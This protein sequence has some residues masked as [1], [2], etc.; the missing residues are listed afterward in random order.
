MAHESFTKPQQPKPISRDDTRLNAESKIRAAVAVTSW[1]DS[2][3]QGEQEAVSRIEAVSGIPEK[4]T[5]SGNACARA[6]KSERQ[7]GVGDRSEGT[8]VAASGSRHVGHSDQSA[9]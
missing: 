8:I 7:I 3:E 9:R 5:T 2:Q 6:E 1:P 4:Q